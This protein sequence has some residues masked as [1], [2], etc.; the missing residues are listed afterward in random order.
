MVLASF[1][2]KAAILYKLHW[3]SIVKRKEKMSNLHLF[4][5]RF[6]F[7][8]ILSLYVRFEEINL[9]EMLL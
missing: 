2:K 5:S 7:Y 8:L 1:R 6:N 9:S 4:K 3:K